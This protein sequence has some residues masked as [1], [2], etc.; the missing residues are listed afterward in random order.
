MMIRSRIQ[1]TILIPM[2]AV[3]CGA[4]VSDERHGVG[5]SG[6]GTI[7]T[8]G[9]PSSSD[10]AADSGDVPSSAEDGEAA[11]D[12]DDAGL[13]SGISSGLIH[14]RLRRGPLRPS[15]S[16]I[17]ERVIR[18]AKSVEVGSAKQGQRVTRLHILGGGRDTQN[19]RVRWN[20][21]PMWLLA[22]LYV[23]D[24]CALETFAIVLSSISPVTL[25]PLSA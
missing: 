16:F 12:A 11:T 13:G 4:K 18:G 2:L 24:P 21:R 9:T 14:P 17:F 8:P 23:Y 3:A 1:V 5:D 10:S 22:A 19:V 7:T 20:R 25:R 15:W 6:S